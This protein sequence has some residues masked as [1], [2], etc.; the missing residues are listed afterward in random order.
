MTYKYF[1]RFGIESMSETLTC[2]TFLFGKWFRLT[3][4]SDIFEPLRKSNICLAT[5]AWREIYLACDCTNVLLVRLTKQV[6]SM[7]QSLLRYNLNLVQF[8]CVD[9][10]MHTKIIYDL[11]IHICSNEED[12]RD[13]L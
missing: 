5:P 7:D 12:I 3:R 8:V 10:G 4:K 1:T 9:L 11:L 2:L 6:F 13:P